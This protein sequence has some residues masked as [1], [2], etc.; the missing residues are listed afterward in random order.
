MAEQ[1]LFPSLET[2]AAA[3]PR[4]QVN[5]VKRAPPCGGPDSGR[6]VRAVGVPAAGQATT[7]AAGALRAKAQ[8]QED[9]KADDEEDHPADGHEGDVLDERHVGWWGGWLGLALHTRVF[10]TTLSCLGLTTETFLLYN[11]HYSSVSRT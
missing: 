3:Q 8:D 2:S 1:P 9:E 5:T 10:S 6:P 7:P 11:F 4:R